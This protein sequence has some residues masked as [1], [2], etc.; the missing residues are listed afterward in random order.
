MDPRKLYVDERMTGRCVFCGAG[1]G[2]RDHCPSRVLLDEP[3][4][5]NLPVVESC[6]SCNGSFSAN[7][8]YL[9]CLIECVVC[10]SAVPN[11]VSRSKIRRLLTE[12]PALASSLQSSIETD[13]SGG[14]TWM[15]DVERV[16][17]VVLKLARGHIAYELAIP[18][19]HH[20]DTIG[21]TPLIAM[22]TEARLA[23]EAEPAAVV[24]PEVGCRAF[25]R[26]DL[27]DGPPYLGDGWINVQ[28]GRYRY[29]VTQSEGDRDVVRIVIGEYLACQVS[30]R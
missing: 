5:A 20:P 15:V 6:E 10:G 9:A 18:K 27:A 30:W 19:T 25:T 2:T 11:K 4:P 3:L 8:L 13:K 7:E 23:F 1:P 17:N 21:F 24:W 14:L 29:L 22:S 12:N 16:R 28:P 26:T